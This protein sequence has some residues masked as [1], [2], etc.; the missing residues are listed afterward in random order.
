MPVRT[1][2][3]R[4]RCR[5]ECGPALRFTCSITGFVFEYVFE[6]SVC[7]RHMSGFSGFSFTRSYLCVFL[8]STIQKLFKSSILD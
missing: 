3:R 6:G 2:T 4:I 5:C 1:A 7:M 8:G